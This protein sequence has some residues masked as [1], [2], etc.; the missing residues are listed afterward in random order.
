ME[1]GSTAEKVSFRGESPD[2]GFD[3]VESE[4]F[5]KLPEEEESSVFGDLERL[6]RPPPSE[7]HV[8]SHW[9]TLASLLSPLTADFK[10]KKATLKGTAD[11]MDAGNYRGHREKL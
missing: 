7:G 5:V 3:H 4:T 11:L 1:L 2:S 9:N 8:T 6:G 10:N